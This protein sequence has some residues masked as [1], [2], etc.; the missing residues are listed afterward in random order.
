MANIPLN[1]DLPV[2]YQVPG[3]YTFLSRVGSTPLAANRRILFLGYKTSAGNATPG[4]PVR[5]NGEDD[6]VTYAGKGS[7][8]YRMYVAL[9]SQLVGGSGAEIWFMPMTA[10]SGTAQTR[11]I[12]IMQAPSGGALGTGN[13]GAAAAGV[14]TLWI[15]GWQCD[16]TIA[17]GD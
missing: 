11:T 8:L 17:N 4:Q 7:D 9:A 13:T 2:S 15:C 14:M 6:A 3:V 5:I 10:P 1:P 16:V 12:K